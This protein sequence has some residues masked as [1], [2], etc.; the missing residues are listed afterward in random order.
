MN[1]C[2]HRA[3]FQKDEKKKKQNR[4][5]PIDLSNVKNV[6]WKIVPSIECR[7]IC[8]ENQYIMMYI[9]LILNKFLS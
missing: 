7:K 5:Q 6:N 9:G 2:V 3:K 4:Q 8:D 1:A